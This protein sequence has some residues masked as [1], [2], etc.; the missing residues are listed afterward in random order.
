MIEITRSSVSKRQGSC[1]SLVKTTDG[2]R[3]G[4][5]SEYVCIHPNVEFICHWHTP[6]RIV[7]ITLVEVCRTGYDKTS[8]AERSEPIPRVW[9]HWKLNVKTLPNPW[10]T[11]SHLSPWNNHKDLSKNGVLRN[12]M[13][14]VYPFSN[15]PTSHHIGGCISHDTPILVGYKSPCLWG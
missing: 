1:V 8:H 15:K 9:Q 11:R 7:A 2:Q 14:C 6:K 13:V 10:L 12:L 4:T 3:V 5:R